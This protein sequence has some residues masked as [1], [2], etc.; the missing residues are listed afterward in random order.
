MKNIP[1]KKNLP[2]YILLWGVLAAIILFVTG[3]VK[4]VI[5]A[6]GNPDPE[7]FCPMGG[8]QALATYFVRGSLPCS[9]SSLQIM[10]GAALAAGVI[11][12]SK[13][14]CGYICP[15]GAVENLLT[16]LRNALKVK[17]LRINNGSIA[18]KA[19]RIFKY[20]LVF[21]IFYM[22]C[23]ASEL[24]CKNLDPYYAAATGFKGE[25]TLWM[26]IVTLA[27]VIL[28]GFL[29]DNF[30]CRYFCPLGAISNTLKFWIC[31]IALPV[32]VWLVSLTGATIPWW[33]I[34]AAF[35]LMGYCLEIF[36]SKPKFQL[37]HVYR[38]EV[39]CNHC[40]VCNLACPYAIEIDSFG[41]GKV[42]SVDCT[43]CGEC[44]AACRQ[45]ALR[46]SACRSCKSPVWK[47][48]PAIIAVVLLTLGI[49]AGNKFELPTIN[50]TWGLEQFDG[51]LE[52]MT[53]KGLTTV[54]CYG[55]SMAFKAR[56]EKIAG[57]HGVKTF[58][59]EHRV[60]IKY[61]PAV[62]SATDIERLM[63]VP[64]HFRVNSPSPAEVPYVKVQTIRVEKMYDKM[65]L[66]YLGLQMRLTGKKVYGVDSQYDCPVRV[67]VYMDPSEE[68]D[69]AWYKEVVNKKTLDMPIHG[70]G[71]K[72]TPID[73]EFVKIE[74]GLD[75]LSI[76]DYLH[77]MFDGF[78]A[79][80]NG[81]YTDP[82]GSSVV[83]KR[84]Q[85][86]EGKTQYIYEIADQNYEKPIIRKSL[87]FLSN[88]LS[89]EEGVI[90][91]SL[92]LNKDLVPALQVR[93]A[94]PVT[95]DRIWEMMSSETW[96]I[97][98]KEGDVREE[99]ARMK[100]EAPGV[101]FKAE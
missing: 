84:A 7:S 45:N 9:M 70:G 17:A 100:F 18:D 57:V 47:W 11:L 76:S 92:C 34:L 99:P 101:S 13:L 20:A 65:S 89:S 30:W 85:Q 77:Y 72:Q 54:K 22:T 46:I 37:V 94:A 75:T 48:V 41:K 43:L 19:L 1:V 63:F 95:A 60:V 78:N 88:W 6:A 97:T 90:S 66:N 81:R 38:D 8:L 23:T 52:T 21:V 82:D 40:H 74:E 79:S 56:L 33:V 49:I 44:V 67:R 42:T 10:M 55:S 98:Y 28:G 91:F 68:L 86:Y 51:N 35:C 71:V 87:P 73:L 2:R 64:S 61:D 58:V 16:R 25:I 39:A 59:R 32:I 80:F 5:P 27:L 69:K 26:S 31:V 96:T 15:I 14:F 53:M 12:F 93:Y 62:I 36:H 50:E 29:V 24:F 3:L 83:R 4:L